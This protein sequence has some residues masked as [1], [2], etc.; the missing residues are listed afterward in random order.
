M[1]C[2]NSLNSCRKMLRCNLKL[3]RELFTILACI[4]LVQVFLHTFQLN[5]FLFPIYGTESSLS[6]T[7]MRLEN[8]EF[9]EN[10][11]EIQL[12]NTDS[13]FENMDYLLSS[14]DFKLEE[15]EFRL[16][17]EWR[18]FCL[19][20]D[21]EMKL[22]PLRC[23]PRAAQ[24]F[25]YTEQGWLKHLA[26]ETCVLQDPSNISIMGECGTQSLLFQRSNNT[27]STITG[28]CLTAVPKSFSGNIT[29]LSTDVRVDLDRV[30]L[31]ECHEIL[32]QMV[33]Q[34]EETFLQVIIELIFLCFRVSYL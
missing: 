22:V 3:S 26:S 9:W 16:I 19:V 33:L 13:W 31:G 17:N 24:S 20:P 6:I 18:G 27:L 30:V 7:E 28:H 8:T 2:I 25:S 1:Y 29:S 5:L 23:N 10:G 4:V 11:T 14:I 12:E 15:P 34:D 32:S 21:K